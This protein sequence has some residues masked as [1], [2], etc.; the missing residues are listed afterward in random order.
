MLQKFLLSMLLPHASTFM[1]LMI[2]VFVKIFLS[3]M[4]QQSVVQV[5]HVAIINH[6]FFQEILYSIALLSHYRVVCVYVPQST[7][8]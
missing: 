6:V 5:Q 3:P 7:T 2:G 4:E 8:A 1:L